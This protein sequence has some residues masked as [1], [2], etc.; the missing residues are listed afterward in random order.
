MAERSQLATN[1]IRTLHSET[2]CSRDGCAVRETSPWGL[3][4]LLILF[5]NVWEYSIAS[6]LETIGCSKKVI[7]RCFILVRELESEFLLCFDPT[8]HGE[9]GGAFVVRTGLEA[10]IF[11][12]K[13]THH[14]VTAQNEHT[15]PPA[16]KAESDPHCGCPHGASLPCQPPS[17]GHCSR[18]FLTVKTGA[19][20]SCLL[21]AS[22]CCDS[23]VLIYVLRV[24]S[25][26]WPE[27]VSVRGTLLPTYLLAVTDT[28]TFSFLSCYGSD[29][30]K[31]L[32]DIFREHVCSSPR[33]TLTKETAGS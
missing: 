26:P 9:F 16:L 15:G 2:G 33:D 31:V 1:Y 23:A 30:A 21:I 20:S 6:W 10:T 8:E 11:Y 22:L 19:L 5:F 28:G 7:I 27:P 29:A 24:N 17:K 18:D 13:H 3:L 4:F 14:P 12:Q 25:H 32:A